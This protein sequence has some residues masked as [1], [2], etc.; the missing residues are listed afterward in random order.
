MKPVSG[1]GVQKKGVGIPTPPEREPERKP[2][3]EIEETGDI[4]EMALDIKEAEEIGGETTNE[5]KSKRKLSVYNV[6][7][8]EKMKEGKTFKEAVDLWRVK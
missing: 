5:K 8:S 1:F 4:D 2:K 3:P 6:F 7:M